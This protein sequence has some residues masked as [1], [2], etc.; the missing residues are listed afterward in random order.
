MAIPGYIN[1]SQTGYTD[2]EYY[3]ELSPLVG[4]LGDSISDVI[5]FV[6]GLINEID[7]NLAKVTSNESGVLDLT[8]VRTPT[9]LAAIAKNIKVFSPGG[10][11]QAWPLG[12]WG[13]YDGY[14]CAYFGDAADDAARTWATTITAQLQTPVLYA[15]YF[16]PN[17]GGFDP[18]EGDT[19]ANYADIQFVA[20]FNTRWGE[21]PPSD[22]LILTVPYKPWLSPAWEAIL[23]VQE[24]SIPS[25]AKSVRYYQFK[26]DGF[27]LIQEVEI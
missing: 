23:E 6:K 18:S 11:S 9:I 1:T 21:T 25:Y 12:F 8:N 24:S 14:L 15:S 20:T 7:A 5:A 19:G 10:M 22:S 4:I 13:Y 17:L 16:Q 2:T 27:Y 3:Q 26:G